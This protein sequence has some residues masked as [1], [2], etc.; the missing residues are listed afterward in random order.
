[1]KGDNTSVVLPWFPCYALPC[2]GLAAVS[3]V[4]DTAE[5]NDGEGLLG[6]RRIAAKIPMYSVEQSTVHSPAHDDNARI[7]VG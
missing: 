5:D 7:T 3:V 6:H 2:T 1:M 4:N